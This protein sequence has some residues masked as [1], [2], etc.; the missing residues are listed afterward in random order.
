MNHDADANRKA[1]T[2]ARCHYRAIGLHRLWA[3]KF[4]RNRNDLDW[5]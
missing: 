5:F 2:P 3:P 1:T 4:V